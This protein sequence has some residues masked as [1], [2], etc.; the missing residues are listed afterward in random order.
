M[1]TISVKKLSAELFEVTVEART[2]TTHRVTA[3]T[4]YV[5]TLL[6]S[7]IPGDLKHGDGALVELSVERLIQR[8]FE[9]LL[10]RESNTSIMRS[11]ELP[12]IA[13]YFPEYESVI[14]KMLNQ[15]GD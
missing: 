9:F 13:S 5:K 10:E 3:R 6:G 15:A 8:S 11:F 14:R 12:V 4:E 2:T 1:A 7:R